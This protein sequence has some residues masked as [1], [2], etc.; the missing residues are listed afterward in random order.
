LF[1]TA[2]IEDG[3]CAFQ[4][5][6]DLDFLPTPTALAAA[7]QRA[8]H[9]D[10]LKHDLLARID[11]LQ[12]SPASCVR[13][14]AARFPNHG[15]AATLN[16]LVIQLKRGLRDQRPVVF[17]GNWIYGG[18]PAKDMSCVFRRETVCNVSIRSESPGAEH[19]ERD[20]ALQSHG[21][22]E[23]MAG[24]GRGGVYHERMPEIDPDFVLP[25]YKGQG[26]G[27]FWY[28]SIF[29]GYM[30]RLLPAV[31]EHVEREIAHLG[32][33]EAPFVGVQVCFHGCVWSCA[34]PCVRGSGWLKPR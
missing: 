30:F 22:H 25:V 32:L 17:T 28:N 13:A 4:L 34:A 20:W 24:R 29:T 3:D 31:E 11:A 27:V 12:Q 16:Y 8:L 14:R 21:V 26:K 5:L 1:A 23:Q 15:A 9:G 33:A 10:P 18:C 2:V 7:K 19:E 6:L